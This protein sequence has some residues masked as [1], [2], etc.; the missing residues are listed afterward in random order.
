MRQA[1]I[2]EQVANII[3][4]MY[5]CVCVTIMTMGWNCKPMGF[6]SISFFFRALFFLPP[7]SY[8]IPST[9]ASVFFVGLVAGVETN[10]RKK[11]ICCV[12]VCNV[13]TMNIIWKWTKQRSR[14]GKYICLKCESKW[15]KE[16]IFFVVSHCTHVHV[17]HLQHAKHAPV[18]KL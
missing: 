13:H 14:T 12:Y 9:T 4:P 6:S 16:I 5:A 11:F 2:G 10:E 15:K 7:A 17:F 3:P 1:K 18:W 8:L